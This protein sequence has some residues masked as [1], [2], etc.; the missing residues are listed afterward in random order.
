MSDAIFLQ[1][2]G[3]PAV[4]VGTETMMVT[5]G[6]GMARAL[7]YP[8]IKG[9]ILPKSLGIAARYYPMET[10]IRWAE[11]VAPRVADALLGKAS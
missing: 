8:M 6:H 7:G 5:V 4:A 10:K 9:V 1:Q 3:I 2:R 11:Y